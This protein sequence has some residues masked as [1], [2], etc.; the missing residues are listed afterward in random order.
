MVT[1]SDCTF[2]WLRREFAAQLSVDER[3]IRPDTPLSQLLPP[4]RRT[5]IWSAGQRRRGL[6]LRALALPG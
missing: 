6:E 1:L 2:A 4:E 3:K 5:R